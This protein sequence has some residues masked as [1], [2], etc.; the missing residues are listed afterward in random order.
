MDKDTRD[1]GNRKPTV[2]SMKRRCHRH[3]YCRTGYCHITTENALRQPL[4]QQPVGG[5]ARHTKHRQAC[6]KR[7]LCYAGR[8][9]HPELSVALHPRLLRRHASGRGTIGHTAGLYPQYPPQSPDQDDASLVAS[10]T[11]L[12]RWHR[13]EH[14]CSPRFSGARMPPTTDARAFRPDRETVATGQR[15]SSL[16]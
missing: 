7:Q 16:R 1:E 9:R 6:Q 10:A 11:A 13:C 15:T 14:Q 5:I 2:H 8:F 12:H 3:D 4:G